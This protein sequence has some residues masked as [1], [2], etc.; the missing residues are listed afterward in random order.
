M[1]NDWLADRMNELLQY[2][3]EN[4]DFLLTRPFH[5]VGIGNGA[6]IA[7][8]FLKKH[9]QSELYRSTIKGL[10]SINGFLQP[11]PQLS[12]I[13]HSAAQVFESTPHSR[14]DIP[15]SYWARFIFS[16]EYLQNIN[17]NLALNILTAVSNPL[18]NEGRMKIARGCL[19]HKDLRGHLTPE[20]LQRA[21]APV[22]P[23]IVLQS[24]ENLLVNASNVDQFITGRKAR[25]LWSHQQNNVTESMA[26]N[27]SDP[28]AGEFI[29]D[30]YDPMIDKTSFDAVLNITSLFMINIGWVKMCHGPEDYAKYSKLGETGLKLL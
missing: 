19:Q 13:L 7:A 14:P 12:S 23:I 24:T 20:N 16:E 28:Q 26:F 22:V 27:S 8:A 18:T 1:N 6:C 4:G 10:V 29:Y 30:N 5:L 25:H 9:G 3:E 11:D 15:V 2:A 21:D 17:P